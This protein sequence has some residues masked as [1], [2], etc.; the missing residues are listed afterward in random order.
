MPVLPEMELPKP[1]NWQEFET[2]VCDAMAQH[3]D[4]TL[5]K[6]GRPGQAQHGVDI[7]GPDK[8]GRSTGIQCKRFADAPKI[9]LI[10]TE[11]ANAEKFKG[12]LSTLYIATTA[13]NDAQ[14]QARVR[15]ISEQR[16]R[17]NKFAVGLL[18]W[19]DIVRALLLNR[20][21]FSLYYPQIPMPAPVGLDRERLQGA[22]ELGFFGADLWSYVE[23]SYDLM[24]DSDPDE[25]FV[26]IRLME[27]RIRQLLVVEDAVPILEA[28]QAVKDVCSI[29]NPTSEDWRLARTCCRRIASRLVA[30]TS[31]LP[32]RE[33]DVMSLALFL[34]RFWY[35]PAIVLTE[36]HRNHAEVKIKQ[37]LP[38]AYHETVEKKLEEL[39]ACESGEVWAFKVFNFVNQQIGFLPD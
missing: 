39:R 30:A 31:L 26:N 25:L 23:I 34:G 14:L 10:E 12:V 18:F 21:V 4:S 7:Y 1:K 11:V 6:N 8:I 17:V 15:E 9:S 13:D 3:W 20:Q 38:R 22:L 33:A 32:I 29:A 16:A 28:L 2:I 27:H 19:E 36:T 37:I 35:R 24:L 5:Q